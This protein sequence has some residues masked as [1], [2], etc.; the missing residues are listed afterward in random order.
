MYNSHMLVIR[1]CDGSASFPREL[2]AVWTTS[3]MVKFYN[4]IGHGEPMDPP[5]Q[6]NCA[7]NQTRL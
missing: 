5:F 6:L 4:N 7:D 1:L 3:G 2:K